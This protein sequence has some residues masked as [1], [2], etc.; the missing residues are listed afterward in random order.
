MRVSRRSTVNPSG[1]NEHGYEWDL[2]E[3]S[4]QE[5]LRNYFLHGVPGS[6]ARGHSIKLEARFS[7]MQGH[8]LE[9]IRSKVPS[10]QWRTQSDM[11]RSLFSLGCCVAIKMLA[12]DNC[13]LVS[14]FKTLD[15]LNVVAKTKNEMDLYGEVQKCIYEI[16]TSKADM[17][18][19][20][21]ELKQ[22][23]IKKGKIKT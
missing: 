4:F 15:L 20:V 16:N 2:N 18:N 22:G 8:V 6:D 11:I 3:P 21:E 17:P 5:K 12:E 7:P 1:E 23:L 19:K 14:F 10:N 9:S 13:S